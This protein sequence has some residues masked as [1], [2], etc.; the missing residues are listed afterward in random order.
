[1]QEALFLTVWLRRQEMEV[2]KGA[3]LVNAVGDLIQKESS[4]NVVEAYK[5]FVDVAFPFAVKSRG[6]DDRELIEKMKKEADKGPITFTQ[7]ATP[8]PFQRT[9]KQ[10]RLPDGFRQKLQDRATK[11]GL[12]R[13]GRKV[14]LD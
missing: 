10:M 11:G 5:A 3:M 13:F 12:G 4:K 2:R 6:Q 1:L 8:S 9:A 7:I 14:E